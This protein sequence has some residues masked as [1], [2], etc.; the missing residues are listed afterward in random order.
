MS[1][2]SPVA[3]CNRALIAVGANTITSF[4]DGSIEAKVCS[5]EYDQLRD[6]VTMAY[7][8][9]HAR[10]RAGPLNPETEV[11]KGGY[12]FQYILPPDLLKLFY[13]GT[14]ANQD[15]QLQEFSLEGGKLLCNVGSGIFIRYIG[16][17][18]DTTK[19]VQ[20][21]TEALV[22]RLA[23]EIAM[24]L[25]ESRSLQADLMTIYNRKVEEGAAVDGTQGINDHTVMTRATRARWQGG[26]YGR[27]FFGWG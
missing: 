21:F 23:A 22:A 14:N 7:E 25:A 3:I 13:T 6:S 8:W 12:S 26:N 18:T 10:K 15:H 11:P 1:A 17:V 16:V 24:P 27:N 20:L 2:E 9:S 19:F 5:I 4:N